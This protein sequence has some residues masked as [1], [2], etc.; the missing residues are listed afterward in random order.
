MGNKSND[1]TALLIGKAVV[2][3]FVGCHYKSAVTSGLTG[4]TGSAPLFARLFQLQAQQGKH[5]GDL[6]GLFQVLKVNELILNQLIIVWIYPNRVRKSKLLLAILMLMKHG[7]FV[8]CGMF[9]SSFLF[10]G[11]PHIASAATLYMDPS[12]TH[13]YRADTAT[14]AVRI[15]T[16]DG[17]C[18]N[19]ADVVVSYDPSVIAVDVS[20]GDS[21]LSLWVE[22]PKIDQNAHTIT[23]AGGVPNGYCGR[24]PGDPQLS[25]VLAKIVFQV[26]GFS[27]GG[28]NSKE[29]HISF[30][31]ATH[32]FL[33]DG[34]GTLAPLKT[35]GA[36]IVLDNKAGN[37]ITDHWSEAVQQDT[38]MPSP[39]SI[40]LV[41][42]D[43]VFSGKYYVVFSTTDKQSG[44]DHYE[45]LEEP[46]KELSL[47]KWGIPNR[48]WV[49]AKN[50]YVLVDQSLKS[51]I[52][53][54]AI[55]KAGNERIAIFAPEDTAR[56]IDP[57]QIV[58]IGTL[59][60]LAL[61]VLLLGSV[62]IRRKFFKAGKI[63]HED[64]TSDNE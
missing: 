64:S 45:I 7:F 17:E 48:S 41:Q 50:P 59:A 16:D 24:V 2:S 38:V 25:N 57:T 27:V 32:I 29:A 40:E 9:V 62:L 46:I 51:V 31:P 42:N 21:I 35:F 6:D 8:V 13:A 54:K 55:D 14:V 49:K 1:I 36:T 30:D 34:L 12:E 23:F 3:C 47:F 33:N 60:V 43:A 44:I 10:V 37:A 22:D 19:T 4:R 5:A 52:R 56:L 58:L 26:P 53:V 15:D 61:G 11:S 20:R 18:I 63:T 28:G 39:F